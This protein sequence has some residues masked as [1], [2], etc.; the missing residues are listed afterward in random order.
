MAGEMAADTELQIAIEDP[1][2]PEIVVLLRDGEVHSASLYPPESIHH[3]PLSALLAPNLRFLV[4]R[5]A[6]GRAIFG[7]RTPASTLRLTRANDNPVGPSCDLRPS[8]AWSRASGGDEVNQCGYS[9]PER[10][11]LSAARPQPP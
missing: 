2:Q 6:S 4:A 3:L 10:T 1:S 11:A 7:T 8:Q 9:S 5:D